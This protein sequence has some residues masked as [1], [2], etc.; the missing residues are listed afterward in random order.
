MG[1][2]FNGIVLDLKPDKEKTQQAAAVDLR[3]CCP[4]NIT[5]FFPHL[6]HM[7]ICTLVHRSRP[8]SQ[9]T[10]GRSPPL[11]F[12]P[13][14]LSQNPVS[15]Q[16]PLIARVLVRPK[17]LP[18]DAEFRHVV[19]LAV[20]L[21]RNRVLH[22]VGQRDLAAPHYALGAGCC[23]VRWCCVCYTWV[24]TYRRFRMTRALYP[25]THPHTHTQT[26][27]NAPVWNLSPSRFSTGSIG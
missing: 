1:K 27:N 9:W 7:H 20:Q 12:P 13:P 22:E 18:L 21:Q 17:V 23:R 14:N 15:S 19:C 24:S 3:S 6:L 4:W 2:G 25:P 11:P 5:S 26:Q 10:V 16:A 8:F